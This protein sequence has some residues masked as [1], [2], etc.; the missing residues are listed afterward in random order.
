[1]EGIVIAIALGVAGGAG[2][3]LLLFGVV[4]LLCGIF[5]DR[6]EHS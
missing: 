4:W 5:P 6:S 3:L 2:S 1:M